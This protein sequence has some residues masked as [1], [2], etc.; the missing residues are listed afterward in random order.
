MYFYLDKITNGTKQFCSLFHFCSAE[1][2]PRKKGSAIFVPGSTTQL[3]SD[4]FGI[5]FF[6]RLLADKYVYVFESR[7][8]W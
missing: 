5:L 8:T 4:I 2:V 7:F 3:V 1:S 6:S